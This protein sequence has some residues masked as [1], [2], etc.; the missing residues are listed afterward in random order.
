MLKGYEKLREFIVTQHPSMETKDA[1]WSMLWDHNAQTVVLLTPVDTQ[2][3]ML[4]IYK[5]RQIMNANDKRRRTECCS[6]TCVVR[7]AAKKK[8][9]QNENYFT[10]DNEIWKYHVKVFR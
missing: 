4:L 1:F 2:G 7:E 9:C 5:E 6:Y 10:L 8:C 3:Y